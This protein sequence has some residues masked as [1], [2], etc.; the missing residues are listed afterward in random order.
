M[1]GL[2]TDR[3]Y[4]K[5]VEMSSIPNVGEPIRVLGGEKFLVSHREFALDTSKND[6]VQVT[7]H[8]ADQSADKLKRR[9]DKIPVESWEGYGWTVTFAKEAM[10]SS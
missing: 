8:L 10:K 3:C 5:T 7:L 4:S 6:D 2:W 1:I 9:S